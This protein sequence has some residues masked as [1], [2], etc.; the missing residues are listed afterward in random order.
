LHYVTVGRYQVSVALL[1]VL[2]LAVPVVLAAATYLWAIRTLPFS[3]EEPLSITNFPAS[4]NTHP[5][6]N[7]TLNITIM[8]SAN[9]VYVVTLA[10]RLNDTTYQ[11]S[12]VMFSNYTYTIVSGTNQIQGWVKVERKA[13]P[14][15]LQ[16]TIEFNRQ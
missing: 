11:Q 7:E 5:G 8:N 15:S 6:Q 13:P 3:V 9:V 10:F 2:A 14:A 4:F 16:L 12:Y 1:A